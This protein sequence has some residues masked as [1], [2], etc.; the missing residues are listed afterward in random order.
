MKKEIVSFLGKQFYRD[1]CIL[2]LFSSFKIN[3]ILSLIMKLQQYDETQDYLDL[4]LSAI[5]V[6]EGY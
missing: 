6:L 1:F 4:Y 3:N 5:I 2:N